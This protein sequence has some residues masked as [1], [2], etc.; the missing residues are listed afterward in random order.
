MQFQ[1]MNF[2]HHRIKIQQPP[3]FF[4][5]QS[6]ASTDHIL[7]ITIFFFY[8]RTNRRSAAAAITEAEYVADGGRHAAPGALLR[9]GPGGA[10]RRHGECA[11]QVARGAGHGAGFSNLTKQLYDVTLSQ[12]PPSSCHLT[13]TGVPNPSST[14]F[15][16]HANK[17]RMET[18]GGGN[19]AA[20]SRDSRQRAPCRRLFVAAKSS[21]PRAPFLA[22]AV[23]CSPPR[24]RTVLQLPGRAAPPPVVWCPAAPSSAPL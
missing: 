24:R 4:H 7:H 11:A 21:L 3:P 18:H 1:H 2:F 5:L 14:A 20:L 13:A 17:T 15:S 16:A 10:P 9:G 19:G 12:S 22:A 8:G 23:L 6:T